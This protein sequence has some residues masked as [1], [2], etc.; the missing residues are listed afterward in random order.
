M[1]DGNKNR[2]RAMD[3]HKI[4]DTF[5][6]QT[7]IP[8]YSRMVQITEIEKNDY[9][10]NLPRYIDNQESEDLQDIQA[11]LKGGIP[12]RDIEAL[13]EYWKICPN[14]KKCLFK[15]NRHVLDLSIEKDLIYETIIKHP[16][17]KAF[18]KQSDQIYKTW[19]QKV[20]KKLK[21]LKKG[22]LPKKVIDELSEDILADFATHSLINKYDIYQHL[23]NY[24]NEVMQDDCYLI[25]AEGW[26]AE[27]R[28]VVEADKKGRPK[29]KGW[30][31]DLIP[32][33]LMMDRFFISKKAELEKRQEDLDAVIAQKTALEEDQSSEDGIFNDFEKINKPTVKS[34]MKDIQNDKQQADDL[35]T[36]TTWMKYS[37]KETGLKKEIKKLESDL[38]E[39]VYKKYSHLTENEVKA[40][41]IEEKW[42][43]SIQQSL[44]S[45]LDQVGQKLSQRIKQLY[46]G[47]EDAMPEQSKRVSHLEKKVTGHLKKMG[48][49]WN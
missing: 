4:V 32:K 1:K 42:L 26:K 30:I 48:F 33:S 34:Y 17:F 11:H 21:N 39:V 24:W 18:I 44:Q 43:K 2:L 19:S 35:A 46:E 14:L 12:Q 47:Y 10:L 22:F 38:D 27:T 45:A 29:D 15:T 49:V 7:E 6:Q 31:C 37:D 23:M 13:E 3:I 9:N 25:S 36:L 40:I 16:D 28:R 41:V 8:Q 5:I 20:I